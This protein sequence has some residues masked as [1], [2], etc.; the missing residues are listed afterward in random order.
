[1]AGHYVYRRAHPPLRPHRHRQALEICVLER[2]TQTYFVG[3]QRYDLAGGDV[4]LTKPGEVHGTGDEPENKGRL[5]WVEL[6]VHPPDQRLLGLSPKESRLLLHRIDALGTRHFRHGEI[7]I[8]TLERIFTAASGERN[9]LQ[10]ADLQN[11]LLRFLLDF[12]TLAGQNPAPRPDPG[13]SR[14]L[15]FV[16]KNLTANISIKQLAAAARQSPSH[17]KSRFSRQIGMPPLQY[18]MHRRIGHG[19]QMLRQSR[20]PVTRI[21]MQLGFATSQHFATVFKRL[22]GVTPREYKLAGNTSAKPG[23]PVAGIGVR[24]HPRHSPPPNSHR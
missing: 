10:K 21:A 16:E 8:P 18:V 5:Y 23:K 9:P 12:V 1:M 11:L 20:L 14:A 4:F 17:F 6:R 24:F 7:L 3:S 2:G 22:T 13:I 15:G 19:K